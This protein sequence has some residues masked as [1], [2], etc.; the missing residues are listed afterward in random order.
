MWNIRGMG[1]GQ[2]A[3]GTMK[4]LGFTIIEALIGL[5]V[6]S[7]ILGLLYTI[8]SATYR[9]YSLEASEAH[10]QLSGQT[11]LAQ[12]A[13]IGQQAIDVLPSQG[14]YTTSKTSVIF[15]LP[16]VDANQT[17]IANTYD[18]FIYRQNPTAGTK[19]EEIVVAAT[20][21]SRTSGSRVLLG[22]LS[23]LTFSY[24]DTAGS[25]LTSDFAPTK[26]VAVTLKGEEQ[27]YGNKASVSYSEQITLRN[28]D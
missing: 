20:G 3:V 15:R 9:T 19:L 7:L 18:Y 21:S 14:A 4:R 12:M 16:A 1:R 6:G 25:E 13:R 5:A 27:G 24:Y 10:L 2:P 28:K 26:R 11:A 22:S 23:E 8:F 17:I